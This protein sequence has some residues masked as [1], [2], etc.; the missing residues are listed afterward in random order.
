M[1]PLA[2]GSP[3]GTGSG[4]QGSHAAARRINPNTRNRVGRGESPA[5]G[6]G[7]PGPAPAGPRGSAG[8]GAGEQPRHP[9]PGHAAVTHGRAL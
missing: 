9:E 5:D 2:S 4:P 3:G 7:M 6:C 8:R 1:A